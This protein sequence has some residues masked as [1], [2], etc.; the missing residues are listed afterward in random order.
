MEVG[1]F[2]G[3]MMALYASCLHP[4]EWRRLAAWIRHAR[5]LRAFATLPRA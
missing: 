5:G 2:I 1:T 3:G 4:G